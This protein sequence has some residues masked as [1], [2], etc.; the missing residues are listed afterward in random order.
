MLSTAPDSGDT[1][2]GAVLMQHLEGAPWNFLAISRYSSW[3]DFGTSE[4]SSVAQTAK[5]SGG[6][7]ELR[8]HAGYHTDT[9]TS[10]LAP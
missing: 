7:Y 4:A 6:W 10:R 3:Q 2:V 1:A 8:D 5:G 9:L